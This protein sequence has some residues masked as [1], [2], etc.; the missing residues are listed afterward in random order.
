MTTSNT[1]PAAP[2]AAEPAPTAWGLWLAWTWVLVLVLSVVAVLGG[3][4]DL[5]LALDLQ[6]HF[7]APR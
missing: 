4:E 3:F 5:R 1:T 6:R 7:G 2:D